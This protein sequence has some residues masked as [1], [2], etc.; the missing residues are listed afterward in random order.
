M[1]DREGPDLRP[2]GEVDL[3]ATL[4]GGELRARAQIGRRGLGGVEDHAVDMDFRSP[5]RSGVEADPVSVDPY[6]DRRT[7][8]CVAAVVRPLLSALDLDGTITRSEQ[9]VLAGGLEVIADPVDRSHMRIA[10]TAA[11]TARAAGVLGLAPLI[12]RDT[13]DIH[14]ARIALLA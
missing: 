11:A 14:D 1:A 7:V 6:G 9:H 4:I 10:V 5:S 8:G 12:L 2:V 3:V 13:A